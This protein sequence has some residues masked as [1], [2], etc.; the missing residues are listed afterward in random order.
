[1]N[2]SEILSNVLFLLVVDKHY[3][4]PPGLSPSVVAGFQIWFVVDE[5]G[6]A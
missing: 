2:R 3:Q 4:F 1:M 6:L 5:D